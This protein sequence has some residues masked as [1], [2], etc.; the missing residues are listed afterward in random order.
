ME[1]LEQKQE[2][3]AEGGIGQEMLDA[4]STTIAQYVDSGDQVGFGDY[5]ND[6]YNRYGKNEYEYFNDDDYD[7]FDDE[8][9]EDYEYF[10]MDAE[11]GEDEDD[12]YLGEDDEYEYFEAR[13]RRKKRRA[14]RKAKRKN[15]PRPLMPGLKRK[16]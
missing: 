13:G 1:N 2:F 4:D 6:K 5:P 9:D 10:F 14:K 11:D 12:L 15:Y 16:L 8:E 7:S 3:L